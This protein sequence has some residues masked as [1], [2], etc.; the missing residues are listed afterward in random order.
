MEKAALITSAS[1]RNDWTLRG[2][3]A[4]QWGLH[5]REKAKGFERGW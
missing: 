5:G 1:R 4:S 3:E 2:G